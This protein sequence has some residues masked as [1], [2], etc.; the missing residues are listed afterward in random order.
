MA[1]YHGRKGMVYLS[2][3]GTGLATNIALLNK[4]TLSMTTDTVEVT[5]F[6]DVNKTYV[7]GLKDLS[8]SFGGFWDSSVDSL[9]TA[10]DSGDGVKMYLYPSSDS[11]TKY[12][13][14]PAWVDASVDTGVGA[15]V[16]VT[17]NF[18]ANGA[19]SHR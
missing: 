14:G 10:S 2:S 16:T 8:G 3:S 5:S 17:C 15:A 12:W 4:W 19:W 6:G 13:C 11:P 1:A 9:F 18:K 7:V